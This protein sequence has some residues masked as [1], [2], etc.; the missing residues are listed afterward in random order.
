[1]KA[2]Q[3]LRLLD[4][5]ANLSALAKQVEA[6]PDAALKALSDEQLKL[7]TRV[8]AEAFVKMKAEVVRRGLW[9]EFI[10][11]EKKA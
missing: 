1:M 10:K 4:L 8:A 11:K 9:D 6:D 5:R 3:L 2:A 7:G